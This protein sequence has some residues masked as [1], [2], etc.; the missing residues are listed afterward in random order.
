MTAMVAERVDDPIDGLVQQPDNDNAAGRSALEAGDVSALVGAIYDAAVDPA[1]WTGVLD[2]CRLFVGGCAA[3]IFSK[4]VD[5]FGGRIHH[6]DG[7]I[8][9]HWAQLYFERYARLDPLSAGHL[10]ADIGQPVSTTD[11]FD[12]EEL[13]QS[14]FFREWVAPQGIVDFIT[15]PIEKQGGWAA[16]FGV[17]RHERDGLVDDATR[18]RMG[19]LVPHVRRA[20][21]IGRVIENGNQQAASFGDALDGLAAGMFLVDARGRVVHANAAANVLLRDG[22]AITVR[23]GRVVAA[24]R[25][26]AAAL[27]E[28]FA[29]AGQGESAVGVR[30]ISIGIEGRDGDTYVANVLPLTSGLR[31][32]AAMS[33]AAVAALF[34]SRAT[35][36]TPAMP[37]VIARR[38]GLTLSE[39]RVL[40]AIVQAGGVAETAEVLGIGEATVKTHLHRVFAK[41]G[42]ARQA[43]LVRLVAGFTSPLAR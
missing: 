7:H 18:R 29:A 24:D 9:P 13:R 41:T 19:L 2:R 8:D 12:Y 1:L 20:V 17:F 33:Y 40:V 4:D 42:A 16:M 6:H 5:G 34:V 35:L 10:F 36:A 28:V 15:A 11:V 31:R 26:A 32:H 25:S 30:G 22:S 37:E 39:L 23:D 3:S 14:R 43:D 21:L 38:F 27:S